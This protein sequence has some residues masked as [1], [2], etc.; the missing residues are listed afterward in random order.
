[1]S[2]NFSFSLSQEEKDYL[3]DLVRLSIISKLK[4]D[5][6]TVEIPAPPQRT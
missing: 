6:T 5:A 2:D 3:K 1:M 4:G